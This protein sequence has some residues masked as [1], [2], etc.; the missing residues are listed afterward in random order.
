MKNNF[1]ERILIIGSTLYS[2]LLAYHLSNSKNKKIF[3]VT[4]KKKNLSS[5]DPVKIKNFK[6]NN[7][8]H[9]IDLP[10]C[11]E[12]LKFLKSINFKYKI[13]KK[14]NKI[15]INR[16]VLNLNE[17]IEN[18]PNI[19][20][21]DLKK[22]LVVKSNF[23]FED[24]LKGDLL[25]IVNTCSKRYTEEP[26]DCKHLFIPWFLPKEYNLKDS[27]EGSIFRENVKKE[28]LL[29]KYASPKNNLFSSLQK[30][31]NDFLK[32]KNNI[33]IDLTS[34]V[35]FD[36]KLLILKNQNH[37]RFNYFDKIFYGD[38]YLTLLRKSKSKSNLSKKILKNKRY[39]FNLLISIDKN[40][41]FSEM[42]C[43]NKKIYNL[44]RISIVK[45]LKNRTILQLEI[46]NKKQIIQKK[47]IEKI[48]KE[49]MLIFKSKSK[50]KIIGYKNSRIIFLLSKKWK[51]EAKRIIISWKKKFKIPIRINFDYDGAINMSKSWIF[52]I[53]DHKI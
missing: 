35:D 45:I 24:I 47:E 1:E 27:D 36:N 44:N 23:K 8:F 22:K 18:W 2:S 5:F 26:K 19:Y 30:K 31:L 29:H 39:F 12:L 7:G 51:L 41:N 13:K 42:I 32:R 33:F 34:K 48:L 16:T 37:I 14:I 28:K 46:I 17:K 25:K 43:L 10:R 11:S 53:K 9:A 6:I 40:L 21:K 4:D 52:S 50:P 49:F 20:A 38:N 15:L 3:I